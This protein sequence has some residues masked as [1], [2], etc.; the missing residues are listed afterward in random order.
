MAHGRLPSI[1]R[2][3]RAWSYQAGPGRYYQ[4][5]YSHIAQAI[6]LREGAFL[7]LCCGPGWL[8]IHVA[9]GKPEVDAIGI[10]HSSTMLGYAQRNRGSSLN[11]TFQ[12]MDASQIIYPA[13][14]FAAAAA[15]QAA[16]H[17]TQ[18][19]AILAEV[20]RVLKPGGRFYLYEADSELDQVPDGWVARRGLWPPHQLILWNWR[21]FGMNGTQWDELKAHVRESPF[22]GGKDGRHGFYR[23]LVLTRS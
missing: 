8:A 18:P 1:R 11:I 20:H 13:H 3:L 2:A 4:P 7:D 21:R 12:N 16:H 14:T 6:D 17:W 9:S 5:S 19:G 10:D 22:G 15:I 23:R